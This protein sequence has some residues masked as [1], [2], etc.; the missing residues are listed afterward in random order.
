MWNPDPNES[1]GAFSAGLLPQIP[2]LCLSGHSNDSSE[3]CTTSTFN[4]NTF[5]VEGHCFNVAHGLWERITSPVNLHC[6]YD[7]DYN[8]N[9]NQLLCCY[10]DFKS[11]S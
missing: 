8:N 1:S 2:A 4:L 11:K 10:A 7:L 6:L 3:T 9:N 5:D